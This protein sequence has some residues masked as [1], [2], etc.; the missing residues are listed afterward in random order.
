M[1]RLA[2]TLAIC[3]VILLAGCRE[4]RLGPPERVTIP[5]GATFSEVTDSLVAHGVVEHRTWFTLLARLRGIDRGV[6]AGVYDFARGQTAWNILDILRKGRV[7]TLRFTVPEGLTLREVAELAAREL[8]LSP[9]SIIAAAKD[10]AIIAMAGI[11]ARSVEGFLLPDT[12]RLPADVTARELVRYMVRAFN[13]AWK[14]EWTRQLDSLGMTRFD[15][16]TLA[17]IVEGE[18]IRDSERPIIAGVYHNRLRIEMPLQAD[19]TVEYAL[20]L[21]GEGDRQLYVSD[22]R[23]PSP[24]NTY[25]HPGLPPGPISSPGLASIKATL[26]PDKVP[27]LYFVAMGDGRHEFSRTY[28]EHLI[29]ISR[30]R[31]LR[32]APPES[33]PDSAVPSP[34]EETQEDA[35]TK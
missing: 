20:M 35:P 26:H 10:S 14:P 21:K 6:Q 7:L 15:V 17:S 31:A 13:R 29:A 1:N 25:L 16:V 2:A 9:D 27:Y 19:P 12:Y 24:Y 33:I 22:Y 30:R 5:K 11:D 23:T 18:A 34:L 32:N 4:S 3:V 8:D 28:Q